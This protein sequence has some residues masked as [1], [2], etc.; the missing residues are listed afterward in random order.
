MRI[1]IPSTATRPILTVAKTETLPGGLRVGEVVNATVLRSGNDS[2]T[3]DIAGR[4]I[5]ARASLPLSEGQVL[6]LKVET[7]GG[8]LFLRVLETARDLRGE[9]LRAALPKQAPPKVLLER[10]EQIAVRGLDQELTREVREVIARLRQSLPGPKQLTEADGLQQAIRDSG[11]FLES[12]LAIS[13]RKVGSDFKGQLLRLLA[14]LRRQQQGQA[15]D[16]IEKGGAETARSSRR[17]GQRSPLAPLPGTTKTPHSSGPPGRPEPGASRAFGQTRLSPPIPGPA[18]MPIGSVAPRTPAPTANRQS[19][20]GAPTSHSPLLTTLFK[21]VE[22]T[23]A[24]LQTQQLTSGTTPERPDESNWLLEIPVRDRDVV[25]PLRLRLRRETE[26]QRGE[27]DCWSVVLRFAPGDYGDIRI[28]V[29]LIAGLVSSRFQAEKAETAALFQT[30]LDQLRERLAEQGL[31]VGQLGAYQGIPD[32]D[33]DGPQLGLLS[34][35][36][37]EKA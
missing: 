14:A 23:V 15:T 4:Q 17:D 35:L 27:G 34:G 22:S 33:E 18:K 16:R 10:L 20:Q 30:H 6:K 31:D 3:L 24:R 1:Q 8:R 26:S 2:V 36:I 32:V 7:D 28:V 9:A 29:T 12:R 37:R 21:L 19:G 25:E 5:E 13:D 11:L